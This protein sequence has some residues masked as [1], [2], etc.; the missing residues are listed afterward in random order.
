MNNLEQ[1][2]GRKDGFMEFQKKYNSASKRIVSIAGANISLFICILLPVLLIGF[3]W[4]DFGIPEI[5]VSLV[6]DGIVTVALFIIG[7]T[8]MMR[9]GADGGKL[10][11]EYLKAKNEFTELVQSIHKIGTMLMAVFCEWQI[12]IELKQALNSRLKALRLTQKDWECIKD[13]SYSELKKKYGRKKARQIYAINR[14]EPIELNETVLMFDDTSEAF[15]RGGVPISGEGYMR[16]KSRSA[17]RILGTLFTCLLTVSVA[18]TL[19]SDISFSRVMYTAFKLVILLFR[20][21]KGY[22]TGARAYNT[23]EVKQ[24]QS[25]SSFLRQ[26]EHFVNDKIYLNLGD[27]YGDITVLL[28]KSEV[29]I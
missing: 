14:L 19:T 28:S 22:E 11:P 8:M 27:K 5:G 10:D 7:E 21:A 24:L 13:M 23:V 6:S 18:I 1:L 25:K 12:D 17:G 29:K 20:M 4:T 3:I 9:V 2:P 16:K 26:Y 15:S